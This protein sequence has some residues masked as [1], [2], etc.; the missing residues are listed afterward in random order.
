MKFLAI[1]FVLTLASSAAA[2]LQ[3]YTVSVVP[4]FNGIANHLD[5]G[6]NTL[7]RVLPSVPNGTELFKF[8]ALTQGYQQAQYLDG[9]WSSSDPFM[10]T[11]SPG[12]GAFL[13]TDTAF[14]LTFRGS[15]HVPQIRRDTA[16][17][18]NLVSCQTTQ[19]CSFEELFGFPPVPGDRVYKLRQP[20]PQP[21]D[22]P[23]DIASSIHRYSANGW[24]SVPS[25]DPGRSAFVYLTGT[26]RIVDEPDDQT[27]LAG[28][29]VQMFVYAIGDSPLSYQ[30]RL[31]NQPLLGQTGSTLT[32]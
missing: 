30:W 1:G 19:R 21:S 26:L 5:N 6:P 24:D 25:F 32:F 11:L 8:D 20:L 31:N 17:G 12:E 16:A 28:A 15:T 7:D 2:Q 27:V 14:S 22:N 18:Y 4:G 23:E 29:S 10:Q 9:Q 13:R 3:S